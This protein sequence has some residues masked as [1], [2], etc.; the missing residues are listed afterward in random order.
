MQRAS[1]SVAAQVPQ[2]D[3]YRARPDLAQPDQLRFHHDRHTMRSA[4]GVHEASDG[5]GED[6]HMGTLPDPI[7]DCVNND[8]VDKKFELQHRDFREMRQRNVLGA[9]VW[10]R[11]QGRHI[12]LE[13]VDILGCYS[14]AGEWVRLNC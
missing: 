12:S 6:F 7:F 11:D 8:D 1:P 3:S 4:L 13:I 5:A 10:L 9:E 14:K 2:M